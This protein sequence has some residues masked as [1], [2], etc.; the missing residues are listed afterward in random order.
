MPIWSQKEMLPF[1]WVDPG[2]LEGIQ[3]RVPCSLTGSP[4]EGPK[5][6]A[7]LKKQQRSGQ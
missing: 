6:E 5:F 7:L 3:S 2:N 4:D 1:R